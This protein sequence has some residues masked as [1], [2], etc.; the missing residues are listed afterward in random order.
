M[1]RS[2]LLLL[3]MLLAGCD[4]SQRLAVQPTA[5]GDRFAALPADA[6]AHWPDPGWWQGF[7]SDELDRLIEQA[8]QNNRD[9][10]AA[11][12]RVAQAEAATRISRAAL[13]PSLDADAS[14][15]RGRT[16]S[17]VD[18]TRTSYGAGLSASY[19]LDLAGELRDRANASDIRLLGSVYDRDAVALTL[20]ADTASAYFTVLALR[21][22]LALARDTLDAATRIL[23]IVRVQAGAGQTSDLEVQQQLSAVRS[24]EA[25]AAGL[26]SDLAQQVNV[27]ATLLGLPPEAATV[28]EPTLNG[29]SLPPIVAGLPSE[30]LRRRPDLARAEADLAS[31]G[32]D[33]KAARAARF[34]IVAL[35]ASGGLQSTQLRDLVSIDGAVWSLAGAVTAPV[36]DA[37]RLRASED[38]AVARYQELAANYSQSILSA[39]QDVENALIAAAAAERI[40]ILRQAAYVA[41]RNAYRIAELRFRTGATDFLSVLTAQQTSFTAA[42]T[43]AQANLARFSAS[44]GLYRALGGGWQAPPDPLAPQS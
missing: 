3:A 11:A 34:P 5:T 44:V 32:F 4:I 42:D 24:Q 26:Q 28:A 40:Y 43:L 41:A 21:D 18:R 12:Q 39:L 29:L 6:P 1:R 37:G 17:S 16:S 27:L 13:F 25:A 2:H 14:V 22:R 7:S 33:A 9:L 35:T 36:F 19:E 30:L 31:A 23:G 20:T 15:N 8:S 10:E 38:Q